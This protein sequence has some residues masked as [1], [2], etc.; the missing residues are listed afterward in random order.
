MADGEQ[1]RIAREIYERL[2]GAVEAVK[3]QSYVEYG[4]R[5]MKLLTECA[6]SVKGERHE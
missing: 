2:G 5:F 3:Y 1:A 4:Q 6:E